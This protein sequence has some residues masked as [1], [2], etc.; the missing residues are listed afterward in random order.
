MHLKNI[1]LTNDGLNIEFQN[2]AKDCFPY[3]WLRDHC[4]DI[5][6]WDER[7]NQRK[8][9]TALVDP[10]IKIEETKIIEDNKKIEVKWPDMNKSVHYSGDFLYKNSLENISS[11]SGEVLWDKQSINNA[12]LEIK[13]D[14]LD[15]NEGFKNL[16]QT[17]KTYGFSIINN[18]PTEMKTVEDIANKIGYV[19][20]SIFG[21]LW[22]FES[23]TEMADSAYTQE[24]LRPHTD[25]TYNHDAPGLQLLLCCEYEA[26]GGESIMVDGFK[27]AQILRENHETSYNILS[28]IDIP[29]RY[30]GDGVELI[31]KRPVFKFRNKKLIQVSFNNY[32]RGDFRLPN[33][34]IN[35]FYTAIR[36]FDKLANAKEMQWRQILKPGQ[37]LIF[38][39]WRVLHGRSEFS[40][41]RKMSG[42]YIN[43][44]DFESV[45][46][47]KSIY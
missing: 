20:N 18:C 3:I 35:D 43:K 12:E 23:N 33:N 40:G 7:S 25:G 47:M 16:L 34:K 44:E 30:F 38:N 45:C 31:A 4:K 39:N 27:I 29:G 5:E 42:C 28:E 46:R 1:S 2:G 10:N 19:R 24:E 14:D 15:K 22:S 6:N 21:D 8:L 11:N 41:K 26:E 17:I 9:F 37:L 36:A 13:F 32:D